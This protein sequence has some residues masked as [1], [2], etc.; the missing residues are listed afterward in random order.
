MQCKHGLVQPTSLNKS[1]KQIPDSVRDQN[2]VEEAKPGLGQMWHV[3]V[4]LTSTI[5]YSFHPCATK[6]P[7]WGMD[8]RHTQWTKQVTSHMDSQNEPTWSVNGVD[9]L[10]T[11]RF[12]PENLTTYKKSPKKIP[13]QA[14]TVLQVPGLIWKHFVDH[15]FS[16]KR[17][18][19]EPNIGNWTAHEMGT[20]TD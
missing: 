2:A 3:C 17:D 8:R 6:V 5:V 14:L 9:M 18:R 20:M 19:V 12:Y 13:L 4:A 16:R 15:S 7:T 1:F 10:I 11:L